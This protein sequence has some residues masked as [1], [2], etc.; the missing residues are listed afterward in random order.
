MEV[1]K[2]KRISTKI[3][4]SDFEKLMQLVISSEYKLW[5]LVFLIS[6]IE[7]LKLFI[8]SKIEFLAVQSLD[9]RLLPTL[10]SYFEIFDFKKLK[11]LISCSWFK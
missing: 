7:S 10:L 3:K 9:W 4:N 6:T 1:G 5:N 8:I 2:I 11:Y